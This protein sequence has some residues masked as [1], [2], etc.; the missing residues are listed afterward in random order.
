[1]S[2]N[3]GALLSSLT[4]AG[5]DPSTIGNVL[6]QTASGAFGGQT[7]VQGFLTAIVANPGNMTLRNNMINAI[8]GTAGIPADVFP[9]LE[10]LRD[11]AATPLALAQTADQIQRQIQAEHSWFGG[12]G[13]GGHYWGGPGHPAGTMRRF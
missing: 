12:G 8:E 1:M 7:Q 9:M 6:S 13:I 10:A 4:A 3:F 2:F 11:P 5:L